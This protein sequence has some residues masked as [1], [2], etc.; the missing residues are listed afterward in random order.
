[1]RMCVRSL[2]SMAGRWVTAKRHSGNS[3]PPGRWEG[4]RR[5]G[6]IMGAAAQANC[7][8]FVSRF[9]KADVVWGV[10]GGCVAFG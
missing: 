2:G 4:Q 1:M 7:V 9:G 5:G 3:R 10:Y 6:Q 8:R